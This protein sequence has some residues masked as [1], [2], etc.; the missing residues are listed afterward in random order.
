MIVTNSYLRLRALGIRVHLFGSVYHFAFI[1]N[2]YSG[3][4]N[5]RFHFWLFHARCRKTVIDLPGI[6]N[7][8][9]G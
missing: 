9:L 4:N 6:F 1:L 3:L 2:R 7:V 5:G 8:A